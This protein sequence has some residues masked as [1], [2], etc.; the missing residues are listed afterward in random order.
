MLVLVHSQTPQAEKN[1]VR[2]RILQAEEKL[3]SP[4]ISKVEEKLL[5]LLIP[6]PHRPRGN[7]TA[8]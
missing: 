3:D 4:R 7:S 5:R 6:Q 8:H 2:P 1:L